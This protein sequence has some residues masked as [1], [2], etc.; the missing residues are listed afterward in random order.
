[1]PFLSMVLCASLRE[2]FVNRIE[3]AI[4]LYASYEL[5]Y[6]L[7]FKIKFLFLF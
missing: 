7:I 3:R 1:M 4:A 6:F 5:D 2:S